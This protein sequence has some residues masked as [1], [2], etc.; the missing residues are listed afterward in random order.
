MNTVK[1]GSLELMELFLKK[2]N[3]K[4]L[5]DKI[6]RISLNLR[7]SKEKRLIPDTIRCEY[8]NYKNINQ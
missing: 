1:F 8:N 2:T 5:K 4:Y 3:I 7:M 6:L